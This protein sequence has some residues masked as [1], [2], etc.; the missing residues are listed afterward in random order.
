MPRACDSAIVELWHVVLLGV[1]KRPLM[2]VDAF[3]NVQHN[4]GRNIEYRRGRQIVSVTKDPAVHCV[5]SCTGS[6]RFLQSTVEVG[7]IDNRNLKYFTAC[8]SFKMLPSRSLRCSGHVMQPR[9][10]SMNLTC[11]SIIP[12]PSIRG[13]AAVRTPRRPGHSRRSDQMRPGF[14]RCMDAGH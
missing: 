10:S 1:V 9:S 7:C 6:L 5:Q 12:C 14:L 11:R 8:V 4:L 2:A 13:V 3:N